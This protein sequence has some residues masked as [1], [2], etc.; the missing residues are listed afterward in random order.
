MPEDNNDSALACKG[1]CNLLAN[2]V[3]FEDRSNPYRNVVYG[4]DCNNP[5]GMIFD[6]GYF[7]TYLEKGQDVHWKNLYYFPEM[8]D[9]FIDDEHMEYSSIPETTPLPQTTKTNHV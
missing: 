2:H 4:A 3:I 8:G 9:P 7:V 1:A 5:K 6:V